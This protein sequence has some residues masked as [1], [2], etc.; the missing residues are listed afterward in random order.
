MIRIVIAT[1]LALSI[2]ACTL[3]G[4]ET[5]STKTEYKADES[6]AGRLDSIERRLDAI[7]RRLNESS[8]N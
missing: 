6:V 8:R 2:S 4:V 7:E 5:K 3:F 1:L